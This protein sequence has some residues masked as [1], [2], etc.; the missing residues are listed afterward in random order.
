VAEA[1]TYLAD[2][3]MFLQRYLEAEVHYKRALKIYASSHG[4]ESMIYSMALRNLA[5]AYSAR[6]KIEEASRL[7]Y[8]A[9]GIF[10]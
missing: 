2:L 3:Y 6:G 5:E 4:E 8:Q 7:R 1:S 9:R 10:G